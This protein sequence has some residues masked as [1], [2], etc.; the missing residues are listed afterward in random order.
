MDYTISYDLGQVTFLNPES[1][2]GSGTTQISARFEE[3]GLFAV[4]PTTILGL[5]TTYNLGETGTI[6]LIGIY[7][8]EQSAFN[9][10]PLGFGP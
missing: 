2:F 5:A 6:N 8:R 10:P 4:A 9:R 7:Q 1:L 3:Q